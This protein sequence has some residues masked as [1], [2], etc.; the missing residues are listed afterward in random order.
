MEDEKL[1][2]ITSDKERVKSIVGMVDLI[3]KRINATKGKEFST[4]LLGDYYEIVK[5]LT[6]AVLNLDGYKTL[7]HKALFD[8]LKNNYDNFTLSELELMEELRKLRNKVVYEGFFIKPAYLERNETVIKNII[9]KLKSIVN[10]K[11][12]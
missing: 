8:Y 10:K 9:S 1:I 6:T 5:E 2:K 11:L 3:E 4:L 12:I 7:S